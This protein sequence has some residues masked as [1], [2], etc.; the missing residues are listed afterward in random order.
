L[1]TTSMA[2]KA[3]GPTLAISS[4]SPPP[5]APEVDGPTSSSMS[6]RPSSGPIRSARQ[7]TAGGPAQAA[8]TSTSTP[9]SEPR[10]A[11]LLPSPAM[12]YNGPDTFTYQAKDTDNN[13]SNIATVVITV[14]EVPAAPAV[15]LA[16][17]SDTGASSSDGVTADNTP[18]FV[19]TAE[20]GSTV[21]LYIDGTT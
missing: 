19:G 4:N 14:N 8:P 17:G 21:T 7:A 10:P 2:H 13:L 18:T 16:E 20:P 6:P 9:G 15:Q 3:G 1:F 5:T 11:T 12:N